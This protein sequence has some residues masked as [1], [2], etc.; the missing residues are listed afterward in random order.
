[1]LGYK[2]VISLR[3]TKPAFAF[4]TD[5]TFSMNHPYNLYNLC[6]LYMTCLSISLPRKIKYLLSKL[7]DSNRE[8]CYSPTF[9]WG[10]DIEHQ[11]PSPAFLQ[12]TLER[13]NSNREASVIKYQ[14]PQPISMQ[15]LPDIRAQ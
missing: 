3:S 8:Y 6:H 9:S 4:A 5:I 2:E 12:D 1:M 15:K 13:W 14:T 10:D 7:Q 11:E